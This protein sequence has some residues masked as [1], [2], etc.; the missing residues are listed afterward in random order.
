MDEN[1][2]KAPTDFGSSLSTSQAQ[3]APIRLGY[4]PRQSHLVFRSISRD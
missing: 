4:R 3:R 2:Y 1:P